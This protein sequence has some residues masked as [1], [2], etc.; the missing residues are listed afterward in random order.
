MRN[1]RGKLGAEE[2]RLLFLGSEE[3][4]GLLRYAVNN[5]SEVNRA[6]AL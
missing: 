3:C 5:P 6:L 1:K 2:A 4:T